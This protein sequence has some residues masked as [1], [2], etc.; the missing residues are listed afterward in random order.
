MRQI[1][2]RRALLGSLPDFD[3]SKSLSHRT[4]ASYLAETDVEK[5]AEGPSHVITCR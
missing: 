1:A 5:A 3:A 4:F 2:K